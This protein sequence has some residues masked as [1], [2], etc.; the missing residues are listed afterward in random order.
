MTDAAQIIIRLHEADNV[1]VARADIT[2]GTEITGEGISALANVPAGHKIAT[3]DITKGDE[4]RIEE[5]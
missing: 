2:A 1:V 5:R 4:I 3:A